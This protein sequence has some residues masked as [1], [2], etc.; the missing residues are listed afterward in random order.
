LCGLFVY[1]DV[2]HKIG[3][4]TYRILPEIHLLR[5]IIGEEAIKFQK[6]FPPGVISVEKNQK[7]Q[8]Q[9]EVLDARK[10]TVSREVLQHSEFQDAVSLARK[11]D[12]FICT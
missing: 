10:D 8:L 7:G 2:F 1:C 11:R 6:C 12:H 5:P 9:A 3:T 4:A